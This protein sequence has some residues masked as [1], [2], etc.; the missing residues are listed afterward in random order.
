M[1]IIF[2]IAGIGSLVRPPIAGGLI[3]V[4]AHGYLYAQIFAATVI[5]VGSLILLALKLPMWDAVVTF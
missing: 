1:G 2:S 4:H 3:E 5:V